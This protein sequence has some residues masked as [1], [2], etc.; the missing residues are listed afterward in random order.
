[1]SKVKAV[2][3]SLVT[4][5]LLTQHVSMAEA[6]SRVERPP[7]FVLLAFDGSYENSF[8]KESR[9]FAQDMKY[10]G[11][12]MKFTYF[13]S[14]VYWLHEKNYALYMPP[15][16]EVEFSS[17]RQ[18]QRE[19]ERRN[20]E[21]RDESI[22][23]ATRKR[24]RGQYS[25]IGFGDTP[26]DVAVRIDEVNAAYEEGHEI[27]SHANGHYQGGDRDKG[28]SRRWTVDQWRS[29]FKQF[30]NL[31][32]NAFENNGIQNRTKYRTGYAFGPKDIVG[33][34]A[35]TLDTNSA[36]FEAL[37]DYKF[38][39]DTSGAKSA[40]EF[41]KWPEKN[42][43]GTWLFPLGLI[44]V[45]G[46]S[47]KTASMDYNFYANQSGG[48]DDKANA[49]KYRKQMTKSYLKY[50]NDNYYGDRS[51]VHIGH[52]FSKWNGGAYWESMKEV[53]AEICAK[54]DVRCA[55]YSEYVKW[56]ES[57]DKAD[58]AAYARGKF[59]KLS[60]P[61]SLKAEEVVGQTEVRLSREGNLFKGAF[62]MD[63]LSKM[64]GYQTGL[65]VNNALQ[66][67][68][69]ID[70]QKLRSSSLKGSDVVVSAVVMNKQGM[71]VNSYSLKIRNLGLDSEMIDEKTIEERAMLGD[72]PEAH[73]HDGHEHEGH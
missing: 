57:Q 40:P 73:M 50:F 43:H 55:T 69:S 63:R 18:R 5:S 47:Y 51:P 48:M 42:M 15:H 62:K 39:Y 16:K 11:V 67:D 23:S 54:P 28:K 13:I 35:P 37:K 71:K 31:I 14:G 19:V 72:L 32:F 38:K 1:M 30:I 33:F 24:I 44:Q 56:L 21:A 53:A 22:S 45:V 60:A 20:E 3:K 49:D 2:A 52:H 64:L 10:R 36:M 58:L 7:Q 25:D 8:W 9:K 26:Q 46:A 65:Q 59:D 4:L 12:D 29:E 70:L 66:S 61:L 34:R 68:A 17:A 27:A 41:S 6:N